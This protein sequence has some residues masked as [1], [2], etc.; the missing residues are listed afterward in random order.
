MG[1]GA[2]RVPGHFVTTTRPW[3]IFVDIE[4][5]LVSRNLTLFVRYISCSYIRKYGSEPTLSSLGDLLSSSKP[6]DTISE[7]LAELLGFEELDL[8]MEV[9]EHRSRVAQE[10]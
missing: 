5:Y 9:L 1:F 8:V 7:P 6:S 3:C 10:V 2:Q 4:T